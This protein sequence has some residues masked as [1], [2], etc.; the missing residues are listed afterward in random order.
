MIIPVI[1]LSFWMTETAGQKS[2]V[3]FERLVSRQR[4]ETAVTRLHIDRDVVMSWERKLLVVFEVEPTEGV[5]LRLVSQPRAALQLT[6][7]NRQGKVLRRRLVGD[8]SGQAQ[9]DRE[10]GLTGWV[11]KEQ[12]ALRGGD[13]NLAPGRYILRAKLATEP[14]LENWIAFSIR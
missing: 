11:F 1:L 4:S 10:K 12:I 7:E 6:I 2:D 8:R 5:L 9:S 13:R 3:L 14:P